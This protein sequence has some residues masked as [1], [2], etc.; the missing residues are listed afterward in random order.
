MPT[1]GTELRWIST[2]SDGSAAFDNKG[3]QGICSGQKH[4]V[5]SS[6]GDVLVCSSDYIELHSSDEYI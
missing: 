2:S 3:T 6:D 4:S 1:I 5:W